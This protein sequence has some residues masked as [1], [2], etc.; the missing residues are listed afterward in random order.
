MCLSGDLRLFDLP[1]VIYLVWR[2]VLH[3]SRLKLKAQS[4][5]LAVQKCN[6]L[7]LCFCGGGAAWCVCSQERNPI[8]FKK[9]CCQSEMCASGSPS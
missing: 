9:T 1:G 2:A 3:G 6:F 7:R 5:W 4:S 8:S